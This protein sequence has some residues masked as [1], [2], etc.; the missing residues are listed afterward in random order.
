MAE[1]GKQYDRLL[2]ENVY[3][4]D[5]NGTPIRGPSNLIIEKNTI[6]SITRQPEGTFDAVIN[7]E[8]QS[9]SLSFFRRNQISRIGKTLHERIPI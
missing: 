9:F 8:G 6:D 3:I 2:I 5:G 1:H 4:I 7:G